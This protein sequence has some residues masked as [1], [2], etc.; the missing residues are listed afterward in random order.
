MAGLFL[1]G[2]KL[3]AS[4]TQIGATSI[5]PASRWGALI[6]NPDFHI[7]MWDSHAKKTSFLTISI[8]IKDRKKLLGKSAG[9]CG[10][11]RA[12][13]FS[14]AVIAKDLKAK[15][16]NKQNV[17]PCRNCQVRAPSPSWASH[18]LCAVR[19]AAPLTLAS[20]QMQ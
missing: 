8:S 6:T 18:G 1:N 11:G 4:V 17:Y 9:V 14:Q 13:Q 12:A 7:R 2:K 19:C 5:D 15:V 10:G 16:A 3:G 20:T